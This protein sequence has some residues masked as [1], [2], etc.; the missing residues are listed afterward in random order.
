[1]IRKPVIIGVEERDPIA[2][3]VPQAGIAGGAHTGVPLANDRQAGVSN[4]RQAHDTPIG[5]TVI[6]NDQFE[7]REALSEYAGNRS[8][9]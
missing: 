2:P 6:D 4:T 3:S 5:R 8:A 1:M 9:R 7:I